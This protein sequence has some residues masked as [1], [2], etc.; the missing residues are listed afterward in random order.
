MCQTK[1]LFF[2]DEQAR[3]TSDKIDQ[4]QKD[5]NKISEKWEIS[6][7][8][9]KKIYDLLQVNKFESLDGIYKF[10]ENYKL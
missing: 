9:K 10:L 6:M 8:F 7:R 1:R 5:A 4:G 3:Q 2:E